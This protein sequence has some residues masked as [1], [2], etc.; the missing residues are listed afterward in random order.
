MKKYLSLLMALVM[1][2]T[3][4]FTAASLAESAA[5]APTM[6]MSPEAE[7]EAEAVMQWVVQNIPQEELAQVMTWDRDTVLTKLEG[8]DQPL[9][10]I[11]KEEIADQVIAVTDLLKM[12]MGS[13]GEGE[14]TGFDLSGMLGG[15]LGGAQTEGEGESTGF[16]LSGMLGG[17]LGGA[18]T[19]GEGES[20]GFDLS[21]MLG[22]LM[23][24]AQTE[25]E[26]ESTGFDLSGMLGGLMGGA[27][28]EGEGE[29]TGFDLSSMLGGLMGGD[30]ESAGFD[31][32]ALF[33][34]MT[35][36]ESY[37]WS[38]EEDDSTEE[39]EGVTIVHAFDGTYWETEGAYLGAVWYDG[40]YYYITVTEGESE[41]IYLCQADLETE[42]LQVVGTGDIAIEDAQPQENA[43]TFYI[44]DDANLVWQKADGTQT[45]FTQDF[46]PLDGSIWFADGKELTLRWEGRDNYGVY[47][48]Q[49]PYGWNYP[50]VLDEEN[51]VLTGVGEKFNYGD[52]VYTDAQATF[53]FQD[54]RTKLV[55]TDSAEPDAQEGLTFD[56]VYMG[57]LYDIWENDQ[58]SFS[59]MWYNGYYMADVYLD[60][61][62]H[63]YLCTYDRSNST[64]T[65]VDP[66]T[67]DFEALNMYVDAENYASTATFELL[68]DD[69]LLWRDDS[70]ITGE[71]GML[72]ECPRY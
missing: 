6:E 4:A 72:F 9:Q 3:C 47:I 36:G 14:S 31:L 5:P 60:G 58:A 37:E 22:G 71:E 8:Y 45:V 13:A 52:A 69:H 50:C 12:F 40:L 51:D 55:W 39:D 33:G 44:D 42:K 18:Q 68:D 53:A 59:F 66:A 2:F 54:A 1:V 30:G 57:V 63:S 61:K 20:T 25:G 24:G 62:L 49:E 16:D 11:T 35:D 38:T 65:A 64:F 15:M 28:T 56:A 21:G 19:E 34:G 48:D 26:G 10:H 27:Q 29:S 41:A 32:S 7:K 17:M 70:G 67:I 46:S 43:D 23:G